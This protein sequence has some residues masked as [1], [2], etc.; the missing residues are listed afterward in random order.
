MCRFLADSKG[1]LCII[2]KHLLY[3]WICY[4]WNSHR[5]AVLPAF[6][7]DSTDPVSRAVFHSVFSSRFLNETLLIRAKEKQ[8]RWV[9]IFFSSYT[10][11][12]RNIFRSCLAL[13]IIK[14]LCVT[15]ALKRK[16]WWDLIHIS[17][18]IQ[19]TARSIAHQT[20]KIEGVIHCSERFYLWGGVERGRE[21]RSLYTSS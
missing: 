13:M 12:D 19:I 15:N 1:S 7:S 3:R 8:I 14:L 2:Y 20:G 9:R 6:I 18:L 10:F 11:P 5:S 4:V 17:S 21:A 16:W